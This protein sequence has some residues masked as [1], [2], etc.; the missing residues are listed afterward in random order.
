M[1]P[2]KP[3]AA[4]PTTATVWTTG[5]GVT[6]PRAPLPGR[7]RRPA[8][9]ARCHAGRVPQ[10]V[11]VESCL[12]DGHGGSPTA[13][14][15]DGTGL[16]DVEAV[17]IPAR[18][19]TSHV[20]VI[21]SGTGQD[22]AVR[23]FTSTG[24]LPGCGHGTVAAIAAL[25]LRGAGPTGRLRI[26]GRA[27]AV[28][29]V[30]GRGPD[31]DVVVTAWFDQGVVSRRDPTAAELDAFLDALGLARAALHPDRVAAVASPGRER[32]LLPLAYRAVL[33]ALRPDARRLTAV[34]RHFGQLGC[35]VHVPADGSR[36]AVARMF[37]PA[38][39]VPEDVANA[40]STGCL[41]AVQ[42]LDGHGPDVVVD[43][44]DALG[45]PSTV[46]AHAARTDRG[47]VAVQVGGAAR[48]DD[49]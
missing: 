49:G 48:L 29:G 1:P 17:G 8:G 9:R 41:A 22:P 5:P 14:V 46:Y 25:T 16:D 7:V 39:G 3:A 35:L 10:I 13:V 18:T 37:A 38:V 20:A 24:E 34:S 43:Q 4:Y 45:S 33:A 28:S 44:G 27:V 21:I 30:V 47:D 31:G 36:R 42:F 40:N 26:A 6:W 23:F 12:R 11:M 15:L 19:G 2:P 32:L